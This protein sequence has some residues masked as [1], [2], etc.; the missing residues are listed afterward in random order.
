MSFFATPPISCTERKPI[1]LA[2]QMSG[3]VSTIARIPQVRSWDFPTLVGRV[4]AGAEGV[5]AGAVGAHAVAVA[6]DL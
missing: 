4:E 1:G 3:P 5:E 2:A 6:V